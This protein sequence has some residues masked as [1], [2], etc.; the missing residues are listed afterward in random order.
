MIFAIEQINNSTFLPGI[1]LGYEIYDSCSDA[2]KATQAILQLIPEAMS[3]NN[4][5][6]CKATETVP[7]VKAVVGEEY[8]EISIAIARFLSLHFIP[9]I[10]PASTA[11]ILSDKVRFPSFLRTVPNDKHQTEAMVKVIRTFWWN[12][13]GIISSDDDYGRSALDFLNILFP[14]HGICR[15][16]SKIVPSSGEHPD[17]PNV[18]TSITN[19]LST[20][21]ANI[22]IIIAKGPFVVKLFK[23]VIRLNI[24]KTWIA[25]DAWST[26]KEVSSIEDIEKIG[27]ILGF[28]FKEN[29]ASGITE[30]LLNLN[31]REPEARND[32]L[33]EYKEFRFGCTD[34]YRIYL[35]CIESALENC[36]NS[37]SIKQKSPLACRI[38][39]IYLANDDY[40]LNNT[41][42]GKSHST[43]MAIE[44]ISSALKNLICKDGTCEKNRSL[45]PQ[46][47]LK[48]IKNGTYSRSGETFRFDSVGD[49]LNGY[50]VINWQYLNHTTEF[51]IVGNYDISDGII[52]L[53]K[54]IFMWNTD[55]EMAPFSNCSRSCSPGEYKKHSDISCCYE[56][57]KCADNYFSSTTDETQCTKCQLFE[58][59]NSGSS[60]CEKRTVQ[61]LEWSNPFAITLL[62]FT[63]FG[64]QLL[65]AI[66]IVFIKC[67]NKP[68]VRAAGGNYSYLIIASLFSSLTSI[69]FFIGPPSNTICQIR[70][71]LYGISFTICVSC[72][73]VKSLRI[74]FA[75]HLANRL[76]KF[77]KLSYTP[78][79]IIIIL[80][81]IQIC[82]CVLWM[83]LKRPFYV[84]DY[85]IPQ[86]LVVQCDEGSYVPFGIMLG[87]I[88]CLALICF[89]LAYKGRKLPEKYNEAR[90]ITFSMLI[91]MFVWIIFIPVYMNTNGIY[92]SA[93]Q[94]VAILASVYG[95]IFCHLL[96]AC[97][98]ILFKR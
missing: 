4:S 74:I 90:S 53:N 51:K 42:W 75:F 70:Q 36:S 26:S 7:S 43:Y 46:E 50:D 86:F 28:N 19:E 58:W 40:L 68:P 71:P 81:G 54:S 39:N 24:S 60:T 16:F 6:E 61:Y 76:K 65:L 87:Y 73:L 56:C 72:I 23:E 41:E 35:E 67:P 12:W 79:A 84:K 37:E 59:S 93:V 64:F 92:I 49:V 55:T 8:S 94:F 10:S 85:K 66:G 96:P 95:V 27:T 29:R 80:T 15:A 52:T 3:T 44:A 62:I 47:L 33:K 11:A 31:P 1:T 34:E 78:L 89:I 25:S 21:K 20:N 77:T 14:Q 17:L 69:F 82:I 9:Q 83:I 38:E 2:L 91:Y 98:I 48:E 63:V 22:I 97:Y 88:G 13:V 18:I 32:F 5:K 57:I 45:S 30:Y